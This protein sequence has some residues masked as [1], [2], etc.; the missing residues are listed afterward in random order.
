MLATGA[1]RRPGK[2]R[3]IWIR[4]VHMFSKEHGEF[5]LFAVIEQVET[6][7]RE[8]LTK[9][10]G[11]IQGQDA[12][13]AQIRSRE[14]ELL[15]AGLEILDLKRALEV[16]GS[17]IQVLEA[18]PADYLPRQVVHQAYELPEYVEPVD[19]LMPELDEKTLQDILIK[20]ITRAI[21]PV[22]T[23]GVLKIVPLGKPPVTLV[24]AKVLDEKPASASV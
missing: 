10:Q 12:L 17:R 11:L 18:A 1:H 3:L 2:F 24:E 21:I 15:A 23:Q 8:Q 16:A 19:E 14:G 13:R 22:Q 7:C 9:I 20:D 6:S 5:R 4:I